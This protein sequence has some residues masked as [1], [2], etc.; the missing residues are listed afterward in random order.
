MKKQIISVLLCLV[1][2]LAV[3]C[4]LPQEAEAATVQETGNAILEEALA[5]DGTFPADGSTVYK[6]CPACGKENAEWVAL[7]KAYADTKLSNGKHFYL[8]TDTKIKGKVIE[9]SSAYTICLHTNGNTNTGDYRFITAAG[10]SVVNVMGGGTLTSSVSGYRG[11]VYSNGGTVNVYGTNIT[12]TQ[13]NATSIAKYGEG[14]LTIYS[15]GGKI[16][17]WGST[18][19]SATAPLIT[20]NGT[21]SLYNC[22][23]VGAAS[24]IGK[25][26]EQTSTNT[27]LD[28]YD[29]TIPGVNQKDGTISIS[30]ATK[31]TGTGLSLLTGKTIDPSKLTAGASIAIASEGAFTA[32]GM[33]AYVKYF[34][35]ATTGLK[36]IAKQDGTL[37][38]LGAKEFGYEV[39][40]QANA[41]TGKF[42]DG[43]E[44]LC[45]HCGK[46]VTWKALSTELTAY[47]QDGGHYY[48]QGNTTQ[49]AFQT[50]SQIKADI[51]LHMNGFNFSAGYAR[52]TFIGTGR[53]LTI[54]GSGI[55]SSPATAGNRAVVYASGGT[56]NIYGT[57]IKTDENN[58]EPALSLYSSGTKMNLWGATLD[59]GTNPIITT[60]GTVN[61]YNCTSVGGT[62]AEQDD[63][64][65]GNGSTA[66]LNL[67]DSA[68]PGIKAEV[69]TVT[70]S[71]AAKI[72]GTGLQ[73]AAGK[74]IDP[75]KLTSGA[76]IIIADECVITGSGMTDYAQYFKA[77]KADQEITVSADGTLRCWV[78]KAL[79]VDS[80]GKETVLDDL[81]AA[82]ETGNYAY[83]KLYGDDALTLSGQGLLVDL[84]GF[85]LVVNGNGNIRG[86]DTANDGYDENACGNL[87]LN[88]SIT[89]ASSIV[90]PNGGTYIAVAD[91][92]SVTLHRLNMKVVSVSLR[93]TAA[94]LYYKAK[95]ECDNVLAKLVKSYGVVLSV[96]NMPGADFKTEPEENNKNAWTV[97]SATFKSGI[98]A[99]S[100]AVFGILKDEREPD[101]NDQYGRL[102]IYANAY[103]DLGNGPVVGDAK[104]AGLT[105]SSDDFNGVALSLYDVLTKLDN[106]YNNY[107]TTTRIQLD[108]F[109]STWKNDGMDWG[110][111]YIGKTAG[112]TD[113][114][115]NSDIELKFDEGTTNA[116]CPVCK[117]K[118]TW[119]AFTPKSTHQNLQGHY[120][121]TEDVLFE[122]SEADAIFYN[123]KSGETLCFHL[124]GH[125]LTSTK[126]RA[127][128]GSSGRTNIMGNGIVTGY[129]GTAEYGAAVMV[130]NAT[131]TQSVN[132]YGG[133]YR[134]TANSNANAAPVCVSTVG[135]EVNIYAG[136]TI[137][138]AKGKAII[139]KTPTYENAA[140][141]QLSLFGATV[142]GKVELCAP[143]A[144]LP[145]I[146]YDIE[147][148]DVKINGDVQVAKG[149]DVYLSGA[150]VIKS[151][152]LS[153]D[154][155]LKTKT[156]TEGASIGI[157]NQGAFTVQSASASNYIGYFHGISAADVITV[158]NN[159]L[160]CGP[161]YAGNLKF[162]EGT[163]DAMC[164]VCA[165]VV[166]WEAVDGS[167]QLDN[168]T[169]KQ[170]K[171]Y[172]LTK[173]ATYTGG[174]DYISPGHG[175]HTVCF[176]LN[177]HDLT[178]NARLIYGGTSVSNIMGTG[179]VTGVRND[180][181]KPGALVQINTAGET[182]TVN[183]YS[184][185]Y[186]HGENGTYSADDFVI[187]I[188]DNGGTINVHKDAVVEANSNGKAIYVGK[189][190]LRSS[191]LGVY[192][193][194]EGKVYCAGANQSL[195]NAN[196]TA[197]N[198]YE[199][200]ITVDG[201]TING[202]MDVNGVNTL[203]VA[204]AAK[205]QMLDMEATTL[206]NMD[207][208]KEGAD[209]TL[210]QSGVFTKTHTSAAAW[211]KYFSGCNKGDTIVLKDGALR[212]KPGYEMKLYPDADG[213]D[214]CPVCQTTVVWTPVSSGEASLK[215][216]NGKHYYLTA[217]ILYEGAYDSN[218][219]VSFF[220]GPGSQGKACLHLNGYDITSTQAHGIYGGYGVL[221]V[222]GEGVVTGCRNSATQNVAAQINNSVAG[223][224]LNLYS[225]TYRKSAD[226]H[227][228]AA[229][230]GI[231]AIGSTLRIY[232]DAIISNPGGNAMYIG[233]SKYRDSVVE[234][235]GAVIDGDIFV[236]SPVK[237]Q[238]DYN[239]KL[240]FEDVTVNGTVDI[241]A[242]NAITLDG[243][244]QINKLKIPQG[245]LVNFTDMKS[246]SD[247][248]VSADGIFSGVL[249]KADEW[250]QYI[251]CAD[252]GDWIIVRDKQFLQEVKKEISIAT[253]SDQ[254]ALLN[255]YAGA[256]LRYG[257]M[258][259]HTNSGPFRDD[260]TGYTPSTGADG[261]KSLL[262]WIAEM[263]RLK[264]DFAFIVDHG[265]SIHMYHENFRSDYFIG[266]TEPGT[267]I[268]DSDATTA[269]PH[270]NMLF[271]YPQELE[272]IFFK[273][274]SKF[275]PIKWNLTN[276]PNAQTPS[277]DGYRVR[278]PQFTTAEFTQLAKDVYEAG[279]LLVQVHPKYSGY[280][281]SDNPLDYY[282]AD[283][284]GLEIS[285]GNGK[286]YNMMYSPNNKAYEL[287]VDLLELGKKVFATAGSD[288][289][290]LPDYSG[291]TA[292]Y[293]VKDH[294]DDYMA[295]VRKGN[296]AP[297][298]VGIR[299]NVNGTPMGGETSFAG[300][301]LQ[302]SV[303]DMYNAGVTDYCKT[304]AVYVAGHTYRVE[305]YDDGGILM[306]SVID[307]T[308]M[309]Y[310]A[311]DC[312][313]SA[314]FYRIV[315]WD[316]TDNER[317]GVSNPIWNKAN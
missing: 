186:R 299:M 46:T 30:G 313:A 9:V 72:T 293:T 45:P 23:G 192:G 86:F 185:T 49:K 205:I 290:S 235:Y 287:W 317:V 297:G 215:A 161:D 198:I 304:P 98:T 180:T 300:Q 36:M 289:H 143:N 170:T 122:Q 295:A 246:G 285:T 116:E 227:K 74:T 140:K 247:I 224:A 169:A 312:D 183:L 174:K 71:G 87:V 271:A 173:N 67:Y 217:D 286:A 79:L 63:P 225:G 101:V 202:T 12:S 263:D 163:T 236:E 211:A 75:S 126:T 112:T 77:A 4:A 37:A 253:E 193:T 162:A 55:F 128:H 137:D 18:L 19:T 118:V 157:T 254:T 97:A 92:G 43:V 106:A 33:G 17:A 188:S 238:G 56:V 66:K 233:G 311:I 53:T 153:E 248:T 5:M 102:P 181:Y 214:F 34:T 70:V 39:V 294:K 154:V 141:S 196:G 240:T 168:S 274:E 228:D 59:A 160:Y 306:S 283:Y 16:N 57:T 197:R 284:T 243:K 262:D 105:N 298:W 142:E 130:N 117:T 221:N 267:T 308:E 223:N 279:G 127:V 316:E 54:M 178:L 190:N 226:S 184:G 129:H 265:M 60:N 209:I 25:Y 61:L 80:D 277:E 125:N 146:N 20:S 115:D 158:R 288:G 31:I 144:S 47:V 166:T 275:K 88:G 301:R 280:I 231:Q 100:G 107:N 230:V 103:V 32:T 124:N 148:V 108:N 272:S 62:A 281:V 26:A 155:L 176:H 95:Y 136:A 131:K 113:G 282:F 167:T 149:R 151:I 110:F 219:A 93:T 165:K 120:Y 123:S 259:N 139:I 200:V 89:V 171:H 191:K 268:T 250:L 261:K 220:S 48:L 69:G 310:F 244:T 206:L 119:T 156:L 303:G 68:L 256:T 104:N 44:L 278:Y 164:P 251:S 270:Y 296:I 27:K 194:V 208:M 245:M 81:L 269:K 175:S 255:T 134:K 207:N 204:R 187:S 258:H 10:K 38:N 252:E 24:N 3:L 109:Y 135:G 85:D 315:V 52:G 182:G 216:E 210:K 114:V 65:G 22:T 83:I 276:Y 29:T 249:D 91:S 273:W 76:E 1:L 242:G 15:S 195:T 82:W 203:T 51:C 41:M 58:G 94:G 7:T 302:F 150:S 305:L 6:D 179:T 159:V 28:L 260:G 213:K 14:A 42:S 147:L 78:P 264:L 138:N 266:G 64:G 222:M 145:N 257:E 237:S 133:T 50:F 241:S 314:K 35:S 201:G 309:N 84:N 8:A 13:T 121:L 2:A 99:T 189:G 199:S 234:V 11:T 90:A 96:Y 73:L 132:L 152:T 172:Y 177:G 291:L 111:K 40:K 239:A 292:I 21:V 307:P 229:I 218:G 212:C 232:E